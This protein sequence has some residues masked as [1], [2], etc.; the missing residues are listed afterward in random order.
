[1]HLWHDLPVAPEGAVFPEQLTVVVEVPKN[2][3]VKYELDKTSGL[4]HVDR[5]LYS[6]MHYP[7]N[8]GF[9]PR[10]YCGDGDP[11]DVLLLGEQALLPGV[12]VIA[13]PLAYMSMIDGGEADAKIIAAPVCDP[14]LSHIKELTDISPHLIKKIENFFATYKILQKKPVSGIHTY[15]RAAA[16][17]VLEQS[18][19]DYKQKFSR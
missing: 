11:I 8:Y 10:T 13:R 6:S 7:L 16:C 1:M 15:P 18:L 9:T 12:I 17:K 4:L 14:E 3:S 5:I 19:S 2:S